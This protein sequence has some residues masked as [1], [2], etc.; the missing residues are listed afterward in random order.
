MPKGD[1]TLR[2][3]G[4]G[5]AVLATFLIVVV[6]GLVV[7]GVGAGAQTDSPD[8]ATQSIRI[9]YHPLDEVRLPT[10]VDQLD[11]TTVL[12]VQAS[13]FD[14]DTTGVVHQC[15]TDEQRSCRNSQPVRFDDAG[16]ALFQYLVTD[17]GE[18]RLR[19]DRCTIELRVGESLAV[20][21]TVFI[22]EA[23]PP[24]RITVTPDRDLRSGDTVT[25]AVSDF[26]GGSLLNLMVCAAPSTS[27]SRC[28]EPGPDLALTTDAAGSAFA[29]I[30]LDV[31]EVGA[32]RV[33]CGRR[34]ACAMVVASERAV[35]RALP[36]RLQFGEADGATYD[37]GR[38]LVGIGGAVALLLVAVWLARS[39]NWMPPPEADGQSIDDAD[40]ADLDREAEQFEP[41]PE[42]VPST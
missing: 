12:T 42:P 13:G 26:A 36:A 33:A 41:G 25:I 29:E 31:N 7:L 14:N 2:A 19:D 11:P 1:S 15:T 40:Y 16:E 3:I 22:D 37:A 17:G 32:D 28:G 34:V 35:V 10:I 39:T 18:C 5:V 30:Q 21:D 23:P 6:G 4:L 8:V 24:G 27:G 20:I 9:E 38:V